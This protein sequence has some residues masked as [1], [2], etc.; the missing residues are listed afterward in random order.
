MGPFWVRQDPGG[1]HVGPMNFAIWVIFSERCLY[2]EL[3]RRADVYFQMLLKCYSN[4]DNC[5]CQLLCYLYCLLC[6]LMLFIVLLLFYQCVIRDN[7]LF[8][9]WIWIWIESNGGGLIGES[10]LLGHWWT[11][12][13]QCANC[14]VTWYSV[15]SV[16]RLVLRMC[17]TVWVARKTIQM[18]PLHG[19]WIYSIKFGRRY[20]WWPF[21]PW[22]NIMIY[23]VS[24]FFANGNTVFKRRPLFHWLIPCGSFMSLWPINT[25]F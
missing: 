14:L 9:I 21:G 8:W 25:D 20:A 24:N 2:Y 16:N 12:W 1:P 19:N 13:N 23:V 17:F 10:F 22:I 11:W 3:W 5:I 15:V 6:V 18:W 7:K 4:P